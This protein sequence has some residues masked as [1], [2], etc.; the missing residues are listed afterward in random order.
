MVIPMAVRT[1]FRKLDILAE[2]PATHQTLPHAFLR[3][4][5]LSS[6]LLHP[7]ALLVLRTAT[8]VALGPTAMVSLMAL[9]LMVV[10]PAA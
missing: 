4:Q 1:Q 3:A 7:A 6:S 8:P 5:P 9:S 10:N 2:S